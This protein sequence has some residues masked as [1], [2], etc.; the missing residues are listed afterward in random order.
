MESILFVTIICLSVEILKRIGFG[1]CSKLLYSLIYG[2]KDVSSLKTEV[3]SL[4]KQ[5]H[6]TSA[7]DEFAKW[8]KIRREL[9][10]VMKKYQELQSGESMKKL[11]VQI[12][13]TSGLWVLTTI[14]HIGCSMYFRSDP[15]FYMPKLLGPLNDW[16]HLPFAPFGSVSVVVWYYCVKK[17]FSVI[18]DVFSTNPEVIKIKED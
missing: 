17:S 8:A 12:K 7:M 5:L 2:N 4:E 3:D 1:V 6:N 18:A 13:V 14:M 16:L 15:M 9:D 10:A 11:T